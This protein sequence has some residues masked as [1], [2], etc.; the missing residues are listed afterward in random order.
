[1][2]GIEATICHLE[3]SH[4]RRG[5]LAE[6]LEVPGVALVESPCGEYRNEAT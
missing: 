5:A 6:R 1:M 4:C 3:A 2:I